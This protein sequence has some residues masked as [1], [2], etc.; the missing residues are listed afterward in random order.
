MTDTS[1]IK[2][3][4]SENPSFI[5]NEIKRSMINEMHY[6]PPQPTHSHVH[7]NTSLFNKTWSSGFVLTLIIIII[8]LI[9]IIVWL[10]FSTKFEDNYDINDNTHQHYIQKQ[11]MKTYSTTPP[12]MFNMFMRQYDAQQPKQQVI[13]PVNIER[14]EQV[15]QKLIEEIPAEQENIVDDLSS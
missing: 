14:V 5:P 1:N 10:V 8:I 3:I 12:E 9:I 2:F 7:R 11:Q 6:I 13:L 15:E 4:N